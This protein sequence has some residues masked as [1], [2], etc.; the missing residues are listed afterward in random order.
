MLP[1]RASNCR[2]LERTHP[3]DARP[4]SQA[5]RVQ[6]R[7]HAR[8]FRAGGLPGR[9]QLCG[10]S[11]GSGRST[12]VRHHSAYGGSNLG[13][14]HCRSA[15]PALKNAQ[16]RALQV[17]FVSRQDGAS[18]LACAGA[19]ADRANAAAGVWPPPQAQTR[20]NSATAASPCRRPPVQEERLRRSDA[21][22]HPRR[23]RQPD[24]KV[25]HLTVLC[26]A[27]PPLVV[28]PEGTISRR[29]LRGFRPG[30]FRPGAPVQ[31]VTLRWAWA[32]NPDPDPGP[33]PQP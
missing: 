26:R 4:N 16:V 28:F 3:R 21:C 32:T 7:L 8:R 29:E 10:S 6:P 31:P 12:L 30:A 22:H 27:R 11:R 15:D 5:G 20:A 13:A 19:I 1:R 23:R 9:A 17:L 25:A 33:D 2:H 24:P 14:T 18:R